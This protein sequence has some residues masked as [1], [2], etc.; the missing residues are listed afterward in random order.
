[1]ASYLLIVNNKII[2]DVTNR[3]IYEVQVKGK[4]VYTNNY[5]SIDLSGRVEQALINIDNEERQNE[6]YEVVEGKEPITRHNSELGLK[7]IITPLYKLQQEL[8]ADPKKDRVPGFDLD[9]QQIF[10]DQRLD[11][12]LEEFAKYSVLLGYLEKKVARSRATVLSPFKI[13]NNGQRMMSL[14]YVK[15]PNIFNP[16]DTVADLGKY[17][18]FKNIYGGTEELQIESLSDPCVFPVQIIRGRVTAYFATCMDIMKMCNINFIDSLSTK[19]LYRLIAGICL[20]DMF[21]RPRTNKSLILDFPTGI[22]VYTLYDTAKEEV[23]K[24]FF[25]ASEASTALKELNNPDYTITQYNVNSAFV[26]SAFPKYKGKR[27]LATDNILQEVRNAK[28]I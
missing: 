13:Q 26:E 8:L 19:D 14:I 28:F 24:S 22:T 18:L 25:S 5:D 27:V 17:K 16:L 7:I 23:G 21:P 9:L 1:M 20:R 6:L 10:R 15:I 11:F 4:L 3:P 2:R 12:Y